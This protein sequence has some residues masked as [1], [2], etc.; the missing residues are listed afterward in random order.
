MTT[1]GRQGGIIQIHDNRITWLTENVS[2][3]KYY[4]KHMEYC[5]KKCSQWMLRKKRK[6]GQILLKSHE[7]LKSAG[8][9]K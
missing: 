9:V 8:N 6:N 2:K 3:T 1:V 5:K 7:V 4:I